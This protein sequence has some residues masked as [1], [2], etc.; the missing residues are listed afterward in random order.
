[1][2]TI[3]HGVRLIRKTVTFN[4]SRPITSLP[5]LEGLKDNLPLVAAG[6]D[7]SLAVSVTPVSR[8]NPLLAHLVLRRPQVPNML[9]RIEDNSPLGIP[10]S[11]DN[12]PEFAC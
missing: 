10:T 4:A 9:L 3:A 5:Q 11:I 2:L 6:E 7:E 8:R 1:M 12:E